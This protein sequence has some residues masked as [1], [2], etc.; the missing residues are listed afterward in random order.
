MG[1]AGT[2]GVDGEENNGAGRKKGMGSCEAE[3]E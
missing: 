1:N 2:V 3:K